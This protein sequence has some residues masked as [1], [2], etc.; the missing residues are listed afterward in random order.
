MA[1]NSRGSP[2]H[3][4][5]PTG[6][7]SLSSRSCAMKAVSSSGV[8]KALWY[9]GENTSLP[10]GT[11]RASAISAV[12]GL[13]AL[14]DL[15]L[16]HLD[17]RQGRGRVE[18]LRVEVTVGVPAPEVAGADLPDQ[19]SAGLL[20]VLRETTLAG[21]VGEPAGLGS[22]VHRAH[23]CLPQGAEA[24]RRDVQHG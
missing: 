6:L 9:V 2:T 12:T 16:D 19:V 5:K 7:P 13:R 22:L 23:G 24:H 15:D 1:P 17:L 11:S 4:L 14:G 10:C 20:V 8:E 18:G 21:V 3:S